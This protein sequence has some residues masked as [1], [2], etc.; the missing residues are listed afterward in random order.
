MCYNAFSDFWIIQFLNNN[1]Y[2]TLFAFNTISQYYYL[3]LLFKMHVFAY[4][5]CAVMD[6]IQF[7]L[8]SFNHRHISATSKF[9]LKHK[10]Y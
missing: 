8:L 9:E 6:V 4:H 5:F 2:S 7:N 3:I 1:K 10:F